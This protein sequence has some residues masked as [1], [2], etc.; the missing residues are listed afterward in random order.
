MD[1][2]QILHAITKKIPYISFP[3]HLISNRTKMAQILSI[4]TH[5]RS[6]FISHISMHRSILR[7]RQRDIHNPSRN[8]VQSSLR[9]I[10]RYHMSTRQIRQFRIINIVQN[11]LLDVPSFVN[12]DKRVISSAVII[13]TSS[14]DLTCYFIAFECDP[15]C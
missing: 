15:W 6:S 9:L 1:W 5:E 2:I 7:K 11:V 4:N 13:P 12:R 8:K 14:A 3:L 10:K